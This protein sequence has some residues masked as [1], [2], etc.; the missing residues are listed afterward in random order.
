MPDT[1]VDQLDAVLQPIVDEGYKR[2]DNPATAPVAV[3]PVA[4]L[5]PL[6]GLDPESRA[7]TEKFLSDIRGLMPPPRAY[8]PPPAY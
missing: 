6:E 3:D 4:G 2:N 5:D 8:A 7:N 1:T